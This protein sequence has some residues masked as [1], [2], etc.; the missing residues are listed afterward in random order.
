MES[1]WLSRTSIRPFPSSKDEYPTTVM[2]S[3]ETTTGRGSVLSMG[4]GSKIGENRAS[5]TEASTSIPS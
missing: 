2:I 4:V 5:G 3:F 1:V